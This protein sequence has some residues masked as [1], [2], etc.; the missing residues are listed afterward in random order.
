MRK[1]LRVV[2][3]I[4]FFSVLT[5]SSLF[6]QTDS[7][8]ANPDLNLR[9]RGWIESTAG[10]LTKGLLANLSGPTD[11]VTP[12]QLTTLLDGATHPAVVSLAQVYDWDWSN[13]QR[14]APLT[15]N[16][17]T[18]WGATLIGLSTIGGQAVQVPYSGYDIGDGY[19]VIVLFATASS[20]TLHYSFH[21]TAADGYVIHLENFSVSQEI[22]DLY[23]QGHQGGR[24]ELP[25]LAGW[26]TI[27]QAT[28]GQL[29]VAIR[30]TGTFMDPRSAKDW[31][32]RTFVKPAKINPPKLIEVGKGPGTVNVPKIF[33]PTRQVETT[34]V[35]SSLADAVKFEQ[36]GTLPTYQNQREI[37]RAGFFEQFQ[38]L[39]LP[40][41]QD[42]TRYLA[43]PFVFQGNTVINNF[44]N[45]KRP[46]KAG[47]LAKLT[48]SDL[49][50][51]MRR[52]YWQKCRDGL[53]CS[54]QNIGTANCP[55]ASS[56][57]C[58][59]ADGTEI[60]SLV[61]PPD[62]DSY[63]EQER[64]SIDYL[65]WQKIWD[66]RWTQVP[67]FSNPKTLVK[68]A[69][70][71]NACSATD[72]TSVETKTPW[73]GALND[74][75]SFLSNLLLGSAN[76]VLLPAKPASQE[77][78][79]ADSAKVLG[80]KTLLAASSQ[81]TVPPGCKYYYG[82]GPQADDCSCMQKGTCRAEHSGPS[83]CCPPHAG[84]GWVV[85]GW[86][87][88]RTGA[89]ASCDPNQICQARIAG[90]AGIVPSPAPTVCSGPPNLP[91]SR[92][93]GLA[94]PVEVEGHA[95]LVGPSQT[96]SCNQWD[97]SGNC[98]SGQS[99]ATI[100]SPVWSTVKFPYLNSVYERLAGEKGIFRAVF[101]P[102]TVQTADWEEAGEAGL[103]YCLKSVQSYV[104]IE[105][106]WADAKFLSGG[107][108]YPFQVD[109]K[110]DA[111]CDDNEKTQN[112]RV[113]P[114]KIGG[115]KNAQEW[116]LEEL[117]P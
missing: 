2:L 23:N 43:G 80:E 91:P 82:D 116:V 22:L 40:F 55:T 14:G 112:L 39:S 57:E 49:Q 101:K 47:V 45:L 48:S 100:N 26:Q 59:I 34:D 93:A 71:M 29:L 111:R 113:F 110:P 1:I 89:R 68:E 53:Y 65:R 8:A 54:S 58:L 83:G 106:W 27:G 18:N 21:D 66:R 73:I 3:L 76:P 87:D 11:P 7:P 81:G 97:L 28:G 95:L 10:N 98:L 35:T 99:K 64:Y 32:Q 105:P 78:A 36:T 86:D 103:N 92:P 42:L 67:L 115:V 44:L 25:A 75:S 50:D 107:G 85:C 12:P 84:A 90:G 56:N 94:D 104:S 51:M 61:P 37:S 9:V 72:G 33:K 117:A 77:V 31:W 5:T 24:K 46:D 41:T 38:D 13:N 74:V 69:I 4:V 79:Q 114:D 70:V 88:C 30:D 108:L 20:L 102:S 62:P 52:D 16:N 63:Q 15:A 17:S 96:L 6:A 109:F 19:Q 60:A